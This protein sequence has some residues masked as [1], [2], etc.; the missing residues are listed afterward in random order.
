MQ[1][2]KESKL[3]GKVL[4]VARGNIIEKDGNM[5]GDIDDK[6]EPHLRFKNGNFAGLHNLLPHYSLADDGANFKK[7][8]ARVKFE[9]D[10]QDSD[11]YAYH[12]SIAEIIPLDLEYL[13]QILRK[14]FQ[15]LELFWKIVSYRV[16]TIN[17]KQLM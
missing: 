15:K 12:T 14:D 2:G 8:S 17:W 6:L 4:F 10:T 5:Q 3:N 13:R 1:K 9:M 16:M 7:S 11:V